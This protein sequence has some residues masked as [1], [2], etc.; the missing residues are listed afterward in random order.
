MGF[1]VYANRNREFCVAINDSK[2][3]WQRNF[4]VFVE[5]VL[6]KMPW[7]ILYHKP[8]TIGMPAFCYISS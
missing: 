7:F 6:N 8:G 5:S 1:P 2:L 3:Y 4:V